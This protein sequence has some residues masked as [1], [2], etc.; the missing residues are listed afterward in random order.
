MTFALANLAVG[1]AGAA[2]A[3]LA[4]AGV[5]PALA[6]VLAAVFG[7]APIILGM[8]TFLLEKSH[9]RRSPL[10][11]TVLQQGQSLRRKI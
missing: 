10:G 7:F 9:A 11:T 3:A 4:F 8:T 2:L 6:G 5:I 1:I